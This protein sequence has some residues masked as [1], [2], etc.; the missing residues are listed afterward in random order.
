[1]PDNIYVHHKMKFAI[2]N[3]QRSLG[4]GM[5]FS[6][7]KEWKRK[8]HIISAVFNYDFIIENIPKINRITEDAL[9]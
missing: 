3:I 5:A 7:G 2:A 8:R 1:M 4:H 9:N 6:E